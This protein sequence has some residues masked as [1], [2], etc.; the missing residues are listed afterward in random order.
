MTRKQRCSVA[1]ILTEGT[2]TKGKRGLCCVETE[3]A[4]INKRVATTRKSA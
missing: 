4:T 1:R 2:E 3:G